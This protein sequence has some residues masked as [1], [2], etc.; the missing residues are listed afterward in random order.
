MKIHI[1][2][3]PA[4]GI[5][6]RLKELKIDLDEG[7]FGELLLELKK[8]LGEIF[9]ADKDILKTLMFLRNGRALDTQGEVFFSDK[10]ELWLLPQLSGG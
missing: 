1:K 8:E 2:I 5:C 4:A 10:D 3:F 6:D 7:T 9:S